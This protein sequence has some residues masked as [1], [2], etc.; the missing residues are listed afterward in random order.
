MS[1]WRFV[2]YVGADGKRPFSAWYCLQDKE[3]KAAFD[4]LVLQRRVMPD[5][6]AA[7]SRASQKQF[8]QLTREHA[9]LHELRFWV[10]NDVR[11][12]QPRRLRVAGI[13]RPSEREF[14]LLAG[15]EKRMGGEIYD[16]ADAF[17]TALK[18]KAAL[19]A[20]RGYAIDFS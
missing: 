9:G 3:V 13:F 14:V 11:P 7:P 10:S 12:S 15:C 6:T 2:E 17:D 19:E 16:P 5:W 1:H 18:L 20:G 4:F 8:A